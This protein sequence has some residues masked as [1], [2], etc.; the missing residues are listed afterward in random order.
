MRDIFVFRRNIAFNVID[1]QCNVVPE[2]VNS[3][4]IVRP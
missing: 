1:V 3:S 2:W 4:F